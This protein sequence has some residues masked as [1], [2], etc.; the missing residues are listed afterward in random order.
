MSN[1]ER[2]KQVSA[3]GFESRD[4]ARAEAK[5]FVDIGGKITEGGERADGKWGWTG[6]IEVHDSNVNVAGAFGC[7][8]CALTGAFITYVENGIPKGPGGICFRCEG[9]GFHTW[10]DRKRNR[11]HD[12]HFMCRAA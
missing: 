7:G 2:V 11:Y 5:S 9:K 8:R 12:M 4:I 6:A 3:E 10:T 1:F